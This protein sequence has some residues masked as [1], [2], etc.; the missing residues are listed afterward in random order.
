MVFERFGI[1]TTKTLIGNRYMWTSIE[2]SEQQMSEI[3][4]VSSWRT[5]FFTCEIYGLSILIGWTNCRLSV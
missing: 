1:N 4:I 2:F 3:G 5:V